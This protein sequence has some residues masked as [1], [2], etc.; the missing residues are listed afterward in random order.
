MWTQTRRIVI[1]NVMTK[2]KKWLLAGV[3][4]G[5]L[6]LVT[7]LASPSQAERRLD[8]FISQGFTRLSDPVHYRSPEPYSIPRPCYYSSSLCPCPF[9]VVTKGQVFFRGVGGFSIS[10]VELWYPGKLVPMYNFENTSFD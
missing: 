9:V 6:W 2:R 8:R 7:A 1:H 5:L 10:N 3:I 4:Y